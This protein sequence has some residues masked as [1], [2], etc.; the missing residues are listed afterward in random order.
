MTSLLH[1]IV[2]WGTGFAAMKQYVKRRDLAGKTGTTNKAADTWFIGFNLTIPRALGGVRRKKRPL[3]GREEGAR[4]AL[5]IWGYFMKENTGE[6]ARTGLSCSSG[7]HLQGYCSPLQGAITRVR[8][9]NGART[10]LHAFCG[11]DS[12]SVTNRPSADP[13][14]ISGHCLAGG[15]VRSGPRTSTCICTRES[16]GRAKSVS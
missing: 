1:G 12:R 4:A 15:F 14:S 6:Q 10:G 5:P 11:K 8:A 13:H 3:G 2:E 16:Y 7:N 9:E